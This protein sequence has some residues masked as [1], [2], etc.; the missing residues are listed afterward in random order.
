MLIKNKK[1]NLPTL[2][3]FLKY[4]PKKFEFEW[5]ENIDGNIE[6]KIPKFKRRI[7]ESLCNLLKRENIFIAKLDK[8]GSE[9]WK[10]CDGKNSINQILTIIKKKFPEEDNI[11]QRLFLFIQQMV[12]LKYMEF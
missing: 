1:N 9:V 10:N 7:G 11:D 12:N 2:E 3:D 8:I 4:K 6:L 5:S